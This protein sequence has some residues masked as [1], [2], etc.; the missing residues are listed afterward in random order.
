MFRGWL[1]DMPCTCMHRRALDCTTGSVAFGG[2]CTEVQPP[3]SAPGEKRGYR[4]EP[5]GERVLA[6]TIDSSVSATLRS[7]V[8][9][10]EARS[11]KEGSP[12]AANSPRS[13]PAKLAC[14]IV[15][16]ALPFERALRLPA[17]Q[18]SQ[19][20]SALH[21]DHH[22]FETA[23]RRSPSRHFTPYSKVR[24]LA[25]RDI[26]RLFRSAK[27]IRFRALP[28]IRLRPRLCESTSLVGF[29]FAPDRLRPE[30]AGAKSPRDWST[31]REPD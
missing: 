25:P 11:A 31:Q 24:A 22:R 6:R 13:E 23:P 19:K 27:S 7:R 10:S 5:F 4:C 14:L 15:C 16:I 8:A 2:K 18:R 1:H 17:H 21:R 30:A 12:Q 20:R 3:A 29:P 28:E 26:R 9:P